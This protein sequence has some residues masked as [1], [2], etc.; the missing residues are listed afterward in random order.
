MIILG[1]D[2]RPRSLSGRLILSV[3]WMF[4][5]LMLAT[6]TAN[7]AAYLTVTIIDS[8]INSLEELANHADIRPLIFSGS[9]LQTLFKVHVHRE[10]SPLDK[11][12][13]KTMKQ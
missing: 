8:P 11:G 2:E 1:G 10:A 13:P 6:Y 12:T 3:W 7:L 4:T 9:N 5:I